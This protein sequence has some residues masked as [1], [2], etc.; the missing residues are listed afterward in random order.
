MAF[1]APTP[2]FR[3][4]NEWFCNMDRGLYNLVIFLDLQK[5]FNT[6]NHVLLLGKIEPCG[7]RD[8]A[9]NLLASYLADRKQ[10]CQ[11]NGKQSGL[12]SISCEIPQGSIL[13]PLFF[14]VYINDLPNCLKRTTPRMFA[15]DTS[16]TAYGKSIEEIELGLNEDLEKSR[17]WLQ[18]VHVKD[19]LSLEPNICI[20]SDPIKRVRNTKILGVYI[21]ESLTWSKHI[22]EIAKTITAGI[23]ALKRLRAFVLVSVYNA[24]IMP[25]FDH[26]CEVWD[27]LGSVLAER[28][29]KLHNRCTRVIM[30]YKNETGQSE[31]ALRHL[32]WSLLNERR[33]D[34]KAR[35][36]FKVLHDLAPV[37]LSNIFHCQRLNF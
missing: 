12:R 2:L 21:D 34:I 9:L 7:I 29:Q 22:E 3:P 20:G 27:S 16:L 32:G 30:R 19:W 15:D 1:G 28:L 13:G 36:I 14:L 33:L 5:A 18:A 26:C 4:S 25:H 24:L 31:L 35:Q 10:T 37:R 23:S 11:V 6:V 17:L 8:D